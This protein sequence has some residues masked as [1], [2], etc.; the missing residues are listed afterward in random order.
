M[1]VVLVTRV[2]KDDPEY[3][4]IAAIMTEERGCGNQTYE[5]HIDYFKRALRKRTGKTAELQPILDTLSVKGHDQNHNWENKSKQS[6]MFNPCLFPA[7][8][9]LP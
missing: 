2:A 4:G 5:V 6:S 9:S 3:W 7:P 8:Q 1:P